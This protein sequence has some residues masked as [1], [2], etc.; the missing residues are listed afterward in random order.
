MREIW[1]WQRIVSPHMAGLARALARAGCKV[2]YVAERD[3]S[4]HRKKQGWV[5]PSLEGLDLVYARDSQE[6]EGGVRTAS[7]DSI[8]LCQGLRG[9]G[10][11]SCAQK[12]LAKRGLQQWTLM[13][14]IDDDGWQGVLKRTAYNVL[15]SRCRS[16]TTGVL[17]IGDQ[18]SAWLFERGMPKALIFP[19]AY[20]LEDRPALATEAIVVDRLF[21]FIFAGQFIDRKSLTLLV[22]ALATLQNC[23]AELV[24]VGSGPLENELRSYAEQR[25][26]GRV[27][28]KGRMASVEVLRLLDEMDCL[29]LPSRHDGWGAVVSEALISGTPAVCSDHCGSA[30]AVKASGVGG[31]FKRDDVTELAGLL[32]NA[33]AAGNASISDRRALA[34]WASSLGASAGA[35]YFL[36][37]LNHM[38]GAGDRPD[39]PWESEFTSKIVGIGM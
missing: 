3:I 35:G 27:R 26:P 38:E 4:E 12:C 21:Q 17:A 13:E 33:F 2:T 34:R 10:L 22:D 20:F 6:V 7:P 30:A 15:L 16:R 24:V 19:F 1:F 23:T 36:D 11:V 14:T 39:P 31:V 32:S 8:H 18:T 5:M 9:N 25:L 28:W 37:I 29:V